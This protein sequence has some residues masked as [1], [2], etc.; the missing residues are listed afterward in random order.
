MNQG[1]LVFAV[2]DN[3][4]PG[5]HQ[6]NLSVVATLNGQLLSFVQEIPLTIEKVDVTEVESCQVLLRQRRIGPGRDR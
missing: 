1:T 4:T 6:A 3:A 5:V 2:S